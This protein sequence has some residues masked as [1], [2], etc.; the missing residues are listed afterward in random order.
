MILAFSGACGQLVVYLALSLFDGYYVAI[1]T[2]TRKIFSVL[3]SVLWFGHAFSSVQWFGASLVMISAF[4]ELNFGKP[5]KEEV[6]AH[7]DKEANKLD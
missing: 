7:H 5:K 3:F 4:L 6:K 2:T 1:I